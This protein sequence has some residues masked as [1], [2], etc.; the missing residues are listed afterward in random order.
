MWGK[1]HNQ[2]IKRSG[3]SF[4]P[5]SLHHHDVQNLPL[6]ILLLDRLKIQVCQ[7]IENSI[8]FIFHPQKPVTYYWA[9]EKLKE[10]IR[11]LVN[12]QFCINIEELVEATRGK[13]KPVRVSKCHMYQIWH[14]MVSSSQSSSPPSSSPLSKSQTSMQWSMKQTNRHT[15]NL[16][17]RMGKDRKRSAW[18]KTENAH[19]EGT[20]WNVLQNE[21]CTVA[22]ILLGP[23]HQSSSVKKKNNSFNA[24]Y[25]EYKKE[26]VSIFGFTNPEL[27]H[28]YRIGL[29]ITF[30]ADN[31][32]FIKG[33][34]AI[35]NFW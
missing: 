34:L 29:Q 18:I 6:K 15:N 35:H 1:V 12:L 28:A 3:T 30:N 2:T 10:E 33:N 26:S 14:L 7:E 13:A 31:V 9:G 24:T 32:D 16:I 20:C 8:K 21:N 19:C 27:L 25:E 22:F 17:L 4:L 5:Q 11:K 23:L